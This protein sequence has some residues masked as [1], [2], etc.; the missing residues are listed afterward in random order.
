V[1]IPKEKPAGLIR[2]AAVG[3]S[4][5]FGMEASSDEHVWGARMV[6]VLNDAGGG[7]R[8][9]FL[10]GAVPGY[11]LEASTA[12]LTE[13]IAPFNP[14]VVIVYQVGTDISA[15]ARRQFAADAG[16]TKPRSVTK[17][18]QETSLLFN[19]I[20][21][22]AAA[23]SSKLMPQRRHDRLD[24]RGVREYAKRLARVVGIGKEHNWRVVLCTCPRAFGDRTAPTDEY[25][26]AAS[27]LAHNPALSL[28]GLNDAFDRYNE[29]VRRVANETG[30]TLVDLDQIV[31]RRRA[32]FV[33]ALHLNDLGHQLVGEAIA[34]AVK[35]EENGSAVAL[36]LP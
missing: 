28:T 27:A 25:A 33:D 30:V 13:H 19:L 8:F 21:V 31:P 17:F 2:V 12:Q 10:N 18:M 36:T 1:E 22:N 9:D 11:T 29:A 4:A 24:E 14:D 6:A 3:D 23:L 7:R 20:R 32:Y 16:S 5:T 15:H 34:A 26:L 35:D